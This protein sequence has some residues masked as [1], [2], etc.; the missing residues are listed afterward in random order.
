MAT[1]NNVSCVD[2]FYFNGILILLPVLSQ[3]NGFFPKI[4]Y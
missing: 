1:N 2:L 4:I 3:N